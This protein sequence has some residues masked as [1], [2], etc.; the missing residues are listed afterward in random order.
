L[1][2]LGGHKKTGL[3]NAQKAGTEPRPCFSEFFN[4]AASRPAKS[5]RNGFFLCLLQRVVNAGLLRFREKR[6]HHRI[7]NCRFLRKNVFLCRARLGS[8]VLNSQWS[9][10]QNTYAME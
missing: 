3:A 9:S 7:Q 8:G 4:V 6:D 10:L 5:P 2:Y 1:P